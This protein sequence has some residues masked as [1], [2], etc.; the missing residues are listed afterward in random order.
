MRIKHLIVPFLGTILQYYDYALFGLSASVLTKAYLPLNDHT[1][2]LL[3]FFTILT[4]AVIMRPIGSIL[5]GSWGD[6]KGRSLVLKFSIFLASISTLIIGIIPS[7]NNIYSG[8]A[9]TLARMIFM[10]SLAGE[11]DGVRIYIAESI[12]EKKE[13]LGNG[14]VSASSQ[15]GVLIASLAVFLSNSVEIE[16]FWRINFIFGGGAG[17][18]LCLMSGNIPETPEFLKNKTRNSAN[19]TFGILI[20]ATVISGFI[21]GIYHFY[22][23]FFKS[24]I[25]DIV[26]IS[27]AYITG[28]IHII[29]VISYIFS[30]II[31]GFT[32]DRFGPKRQIVFAIALSI[33][34]AVV[35]SLYIASGEISYVLLI[36]S[37]SLIA[38]Y[39]VPLQIILKRKMPV[40]NRLK[41]FSLSHSLGSLLFSSSSTVIST[42]IYD[43]TRLTFA[44]MIYLIFMMITLLISVI[45]C[46]YKS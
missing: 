36:L 38:F 7:S 16:N 33:L 44:P 35:N 43:A 46:W 21:G 20:I 18:L 30:A 39:S 42:F 40:Q 3:S 13:F 31:A 22:L 24:Y 37:I 19:Q 45:I 17:L 4:F 27:D 34:F 32:A 41:L 14:I 9:L 8:C 12:G 15:I 10:M 29:S 23:I 28:K 6:R 2:G 1:E 25:A 11:I 5:F 26:H